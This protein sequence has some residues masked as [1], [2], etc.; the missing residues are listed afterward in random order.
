MYQQFL[1]TPRS[2]Y[3]VQLTVID[4]PQTLLEAFEI[5]LAL[6]LRI[7]LPPQLLY[8]LIPLVL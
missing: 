8:P 2:S 1:Q 6:S 7:Q 4:L 3:R 5:Q